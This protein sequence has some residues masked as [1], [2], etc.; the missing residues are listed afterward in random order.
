MGSI[1]RRLSALAGFC[2]VRRWHAFE[3]ARARPYLDESR[4]ILTP[5][6]PLS[7]QVRGRVRGARPPASSTNVEHTVSS[8]S[9]CRDSIKVHTRLPPHASCPVHDVAPPVLLREFFSHCLHTYI[10]AARALLLASGSP[11]PGYLLGIRATGKEH[12]LEPC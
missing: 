4:G 3:F 2:T 11:M 5:L 7:L 12:Q 8:M 9:T 6:Y 10:Q 1:A